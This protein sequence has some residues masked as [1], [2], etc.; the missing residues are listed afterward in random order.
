MRSS[1]FNRTTRLL[2]YKEVLSE[3]EPRVVLGL[4]VDDVYK[5]GALLVTYMHDTYG[6]DRVQA[7]LTSD[8]ATF[9]GALEKELGVDLGAFYRGWLEWARQQ[10]PA[11]GSGRR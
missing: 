7:I 5:D 2:D 10:R 9:A 4:V 11:A 8:A 1:E 6:R 3:E